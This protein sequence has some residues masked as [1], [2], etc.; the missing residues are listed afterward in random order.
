MA[1]V[2]HNFALDG[3]QYPVNSGWLATFGEIDLEGEEPVVLIDPRYWVSGSPSNWA[4]SANW[5]LTSGGPGGASIPTPENVAVFDESGAGNCAMDSS[6]HVYGIHMSGYVGTLSQNS[7][8]IFCSFTNFFSGTFQGDGSNIRV[9]TDFAI[10]NT[11]DFTSTDATISCDGTF[12]YT[13]TTGSFI[14][15]SGTVSMDG[16]GSFLNAPNISMSKLRFNGPQQ[17][18]FRRCIVEDQLHLQQ[19]SARNVSI[20]A[21]VHLKGNLY[22]SSDYYQWSSFNDFPIKLDSTSKQYVRNESGSVTPTV[23]VD[24]Q[25]PDEVVCDG[26]SP[27]VIKDAFIVQ[28][29]TFNSNGRDIQVGL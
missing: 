9:L 21:T 24:K 2:S 4:N 16:S 27:F 20:D 19:G 6:A 17:R 1:I 15:N 22:S 13:P 26:R 11:C 7:N 23:I 18:I 14:H 3:F 12:A 29:G 25:V 5:S 10:S 28:D 8:E